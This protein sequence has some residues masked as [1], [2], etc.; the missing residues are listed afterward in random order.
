MGL[1]TALA[2]AKRVAVETGGVEGVLQLGVVAIWDF[3]R[4]IFC[5]FYHGD[6]LLICIG[7]YTTQL[8]EL[9]V[10]IMIRQH[11]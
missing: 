10:R 8:S 6:L 9:Y 11:L 7:D 1:T 5:R 4:V 3:L 2:L